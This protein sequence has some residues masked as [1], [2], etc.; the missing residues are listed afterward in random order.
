MPSPERRGLGLRIPLIR[1]KEIMIRFPRRPLLETVWEIE[2][3]VFWSLGSGQI[4]I[5]RLYLAV[6]CCQEPRLTNPPPI[7]QTVSLENLVH[8]RTFDFPGI[9]L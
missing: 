3:G 1:E 2:T 5:D 6:L 8:N 4:E 7:F 9:I